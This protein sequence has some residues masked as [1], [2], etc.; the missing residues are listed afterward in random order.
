[1]ISLPLSQPQRRHS[2]WIHR[3]YGH[4]SE[5]ATSIRWKDLARYS[6]LLLKG[7]TVGLEPDEHIAQHWEWPLPAWSNVMRWVVLAWQCCMYGAHRPLLHH[8]PRVM[9]L[10]ALSLLKLYCMPLHRSW[11]LRW[12]SG[13]FL[14]NTECLDSLRF[15]VGQN[16]PRAPRFVG[17]WPRT[18]GPLSQTCFW[19]IES[20]EIV[21]LYQFIT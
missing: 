10:Q 13:W 2:E 4:P 12:K 3:K 8:R 5:W 7:I 9:C 16:V 14:E 18:K 6:N 20:Y 21:W 19:S 15:D 11:M 1:M 17:R